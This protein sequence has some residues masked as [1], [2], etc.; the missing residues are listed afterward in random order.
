MAIMLLAQCFDFILFY[1]LLVH[2]HSTLTFEK[3]IMIVLA[4]II[5]TQRWSGI[6]HDILIIN[7]HDALVL[8]CD[9]RL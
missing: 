7:V 6:L 8:Y 9:E 1:L 4:L 5:R 3:L 2:L